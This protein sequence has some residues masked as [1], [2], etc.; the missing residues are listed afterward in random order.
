MC[1]RANKFY[2]PPALNVPSYLF[3]IINILFSNLRVILY[4]TLPSRKNSGHDVIM[5]LGTRL[6]CG[7]R[8][9]FICCKA[10][11]IGTNRLAPHPVAHMVR[12]PSPFP[13]ATHY[14]C[15]LG[16]PYIPLPKDEYHYKI[17]LVGDPGTG[18]TNIVR[19]YVE[20]RFSSE[21]K[22]T[23]SPL[24]NLYISKMYVRT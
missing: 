7:G 22:A 21:Y 10:T 15:A 2:L 4:T 8:G 18:K 11:P 20:N 12:T 14:D 1:N 3:R 17:L 13:P 16:P 24:R 5:G 19:R 9:Q 6:A 23:V